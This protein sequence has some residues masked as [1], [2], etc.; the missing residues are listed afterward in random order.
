MLL[1]GWGCS[2]LAY[3]PKV[4]GSILR[5]THTRKYSEETKKEPGVNLHEIHVRPKK[6]LRIIFSAEG[7]PAWTERDRGAKN[8]RKLPNSE[9][10][11]SR[12]R[13]TELLTHK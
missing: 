6:F 3:M 5:T 2:S 12:S 8:K 4:Q 7:V 9:K 10:S 1:G 13:P 11:T